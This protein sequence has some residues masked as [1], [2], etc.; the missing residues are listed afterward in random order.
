MPDVV[1]TTPIDR[2]LTEAEST[3]VLVVANEAE[4]KNPANYVAPLTGIMKVRQADSFYSLWLLIA[5]DVT[6]DSSWVEF[7]LEGHVHDPFTVGELPPIKLGTGDLVNDAW[8]VPKVSL[9]KSLFRSLFTFDIPPSNWFMYEND[10][11]V[12]TSTNIASVNGA[13]KILGNAAKP[14]ALLESRLCP[15]YQPNRGHLFSTAL[16]APNKLADGVREWGVGTKENQ[17]RFRLKNDGKLYAILRSG[18]SETHEQE[19]DTSSLPGFDVEKGNVYDIQYQWRG[20]GNYYFF[21]NLKLVHTISNLGTLTALSTQNP[22]MP[23]SFL[24]HRNTEDVEINVGCC[25]VSSENGDLETLEY[26]SDSKDAQTNTAGGPAFILYNPLLIGSVTNT[27]TAVL[28]SI[29]VTSTNKASFGLWRTRDLGLITGESFVTKGNGSYLQ[30]DTSAT[31]VNTTGMEYLGA[32]QVEAN[33]RV[34]EKFFKNLKTQIRRVRGDC[35]IITRSVATG[36]CDIA[37]RWG[38]EI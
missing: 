6:Q 9:T 21:V 17:V 12:Y 7:S 14:K 23:V 1:L 30:I 28:H 38:E 34:Q 18:N 3:G 37:V 15:R 5:E 20:V 35:L 24:A 31:A 19:I 32:I 16:W 4:R 2:F 8:G 13:A 22:A 26:A 36:T 10:V 27:R 33:V 29:A 25:D 11:Q